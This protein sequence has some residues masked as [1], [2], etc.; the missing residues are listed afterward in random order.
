VLL[1]G[2]C[3]AAEKAGASVTLALPVRNRPKPI[4]ARALTK[5]YKDE[6][7]GTFV[8]FVRDEPFLL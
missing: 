8:F 4:A 1:R 5:L 2:F 6:G 3:C 7:C